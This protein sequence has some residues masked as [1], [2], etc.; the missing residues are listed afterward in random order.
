MESLLLFKDRLSVN[1]L[2]KSQFILEV[3]PQLH[4]YPNRNIFSS[5]VTDHLLVL[6]RELDQTKRMGHRP[7]CGAD[8][9][10]L[11]LGVLERNAMIW[12]KAARRH[13]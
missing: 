3:H 12:A 8:A 2:V 7:W 10:A 6:W 13:G 5:P 9:Y 4:Q 1:I 11:G